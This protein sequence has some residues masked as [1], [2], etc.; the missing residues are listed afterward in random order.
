MLR[1]AS[2]SICNG[3][4]AGKVVENQVVTNGKFPFSLV[5]R[6]SNQV[7]G[8]SNPSGRTKI[9]DLDAGFSSAVLLTKLNSTNF[10]KAARRG[11]C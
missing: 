1:R 7:V 11:V 3:H 5:R 10:P 9:N 8:G 4:P 6:A 2:G